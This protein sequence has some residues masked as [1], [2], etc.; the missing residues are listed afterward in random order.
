LLTDSRP[1][2]ITTLAGKIIDP[3]AYGNAGRI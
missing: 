1:E 2:A 3:I